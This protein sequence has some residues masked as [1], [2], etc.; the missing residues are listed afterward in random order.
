MREKLEENS[1]LRGQRPRRKLEELEISCQRAH[2]AMKLALNL[3]GPCVVDAGLRIENR[4]IALAD[5]RER[6]K[7]VVQNHSGG[8]RHGELAANRVEAAIDADRGVEAASH[9]LIHCSYRQ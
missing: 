6:L 5:D 2:L 3:L 4:P 1:I 9:F 8:L 7:H